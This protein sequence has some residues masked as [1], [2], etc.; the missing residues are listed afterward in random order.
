MKII[1]MGEIISALKEA[2]YDPYTQIVAYLQSGDITYITRTNNARNKISK[3][4]P[5]WV[6]EYMTKM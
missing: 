1:L 3:L 5:E 2:G 6:A 4:N